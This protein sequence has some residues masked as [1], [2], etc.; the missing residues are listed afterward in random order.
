MEVKYIN[1]PKQFEEIKDEVMSISLK[2]FSSGSYILGE[3]LQ[4]FEKSISEYCGTKYALGVANGTDALIIALKASGIRAGDEVITA[5]NSFIASAGAIT[6]IG[7]RPVFVDV[8]QTYNIDPY[9]I[10]RSITAKTRAIIPV[11][12]TGR[13]ADMDPINNMARENGL[14]VIEDA[15]Q[16]I[17]ASY[18]GDK[19]GSL[20][21]IGCF[22]LHPLKT[23]NAFGDA[24]FITTNNN[25]F[26]NVMHQM[27]NHGLIDR[28]TASDFGYNSRLDEIQAGILNIKLKHLDGWNERRREIASTYSRR[29][30][31]II[32]IPTDKSR[33]KQVYHTYVVQVERRDELQ[34]YLQQNG[35]ETKIHYPIPL[36]LQPAA[37]HLGYKK[38]DFP[39]AE[40]QSERILSL[41]VHQNLK[42]SEVNYVIDKIISFYKN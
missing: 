1:F 40:K 25:N 18:K 28:N 30:E 41:P 6:A 7:A 32:Q 42:D 17:G 13:P 24:G 19:T 15:A 4:K 37:R 21:D 5:P 26:Y 14:C 31:G 2:I 20:G 38:G 36:H 16:S 39:E 34:K 35:I 9:L 29:L 3:E 23:L 33:E 10:Q 11:H 27:R 12:L 22:S 8:N